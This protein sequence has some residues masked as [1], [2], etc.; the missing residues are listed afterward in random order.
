[1]HYPKINEFVKE[2]CREFGISYL[3]HKTM[4]KAFISHLSHLKK[5]GMAD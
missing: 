4:L 1:V 3:E 2:T 5:L